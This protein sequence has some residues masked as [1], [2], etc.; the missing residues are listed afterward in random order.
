MKIYGNLWTQWKLIKIMRIHWK[1]MEINFRALSL[2]STGI[3]LVFCWYPFGRNQ[4]FYSQPTRQPANP[5]TRQPANPP[6]SQPANHLGPVFFTRKTYLFHR[7]GG[8][9]APDLPKRTLSNVVFCNKYNEILLFWP[10]SG[11]AGPGC[12]WLW[13]SPWIAL[14]LRK[15][16]KNVWKPMKIYEILWKSMEIYERNEN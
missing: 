5:P 1:S 13:A 2:R 11:R 14:N 15:T 6:A 3:L 10:W 16:Y 8:E 7:S 12:K 9:P 4:K